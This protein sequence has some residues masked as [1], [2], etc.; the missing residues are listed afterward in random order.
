VRLVV[1][2]RKKSRKDVR[3]EAGGIDGSGKLKRRW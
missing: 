3:S 2:K 1:E